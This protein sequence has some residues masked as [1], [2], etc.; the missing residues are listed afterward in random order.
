[1][2]FHRPLLI[3]TAYQYSIHGMYSGQLFCSCI[4]GVKM[5][6]RHAARLVDLGT[7][8]GY[9]E[10]PLIFEELVME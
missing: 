2:I 4:V 3:M 5:S 7:V 10:W 1:M 6:I 8:W 9:L